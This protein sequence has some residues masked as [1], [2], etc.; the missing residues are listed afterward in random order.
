MN[1]HIELEYKIKTAIGNVREKIEWWIA[2]AL[3]KRIAY[4]AMIRVCAHGT[5]G[6]YSDTMANDVTAMEILHRWG[7]E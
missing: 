7:T 5:T 3:P 2:Y 6:E 4:L 1:H